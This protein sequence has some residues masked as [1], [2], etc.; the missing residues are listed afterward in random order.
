[1][2]ETGDGV[3]DNA[4]TGPDVEQP[5]EAS[6]RWLAALLEYSSDIITIVDVEGRIRYSSPSAAR[7]LGYRFGR[8]VHFADLIHPDDQAAA[9]DALS[10]VVDAGPGSVIRI[11]TKVATA[12]GQWLHMESVASNHVDDPAV[13]GVVINTRDVTDRI[14]AMRQVLQLAYHD[15]LTGLPNRTL[16]L[17][18]LDQAL[19]RSRRT[20]REVAVFYVDLDGFKEINDRFGHASGDAMLRQVGRRVSACIR[21]GDTA[22]RIGGDEFVVIAEGLD[23]PDGALAMAERIEGAIAS[24]VVPQDQLVSIRASV[25]I[26]VGGAG[27]AGEELLEMADRSLYEVKRRGGGGSQLAGGAARLPA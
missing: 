17:D 27:L 6:H 26:A 7:I 11:E 19:A 25:G 22:A 14:E 23:L 24:S 21:P 16:L 18:R 9:L 10:Q 15:G 8:T 1:V 13:R 4:V 12:A 2:R 20:G 5:G 3:R